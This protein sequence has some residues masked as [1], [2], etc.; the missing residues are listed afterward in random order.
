MQQIRTSGILNK[1]K[2]DLTENKKFDM[3]SS[4][5]VVPVTIDHVTIILSTFILF[6]F[7]A[8][9]LFLLEKI[10]K[11]R[12]CHKNSRNIENIAVTVRQGMPGVRRTRT[13]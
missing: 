3:D 1:W 7:I 2:R 10:K 13:H 9:I 5:S 12:M 6:F 8:L 11:L 4:N